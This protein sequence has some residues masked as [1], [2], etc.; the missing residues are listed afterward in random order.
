MAGSKRTTI[1]GFILNAHPAQARELRQFDDTF[2]RQRFLDARDHGQ[3]MVQL[4]D[5]MYMIHRHADH[6]FELV[7]HHDEHRS[8][9]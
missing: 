7:R 4:S 2:L 1:L 3:S 5:G 6:T 9:L 8:A